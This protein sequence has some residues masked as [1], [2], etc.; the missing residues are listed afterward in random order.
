MS[1]KERTETGQAGDKADGLR[2]RPGQHTDPSKMP[3]NAEN[4]APGAKDGAPA[5]CPLCKGGPLDGH[6]AGCARLAEELQINSDD[7]PSGKDG[8][9]EV[10]AKL[11]EWLGHSRSVGSLHVMIP[12]EAAEE[13]LA[14][15]RA[16]Q[17]APFENMAPGAKEPAVSG[18]CG[19]FLGARGGCVLPDGHVGDHQPKSD[20]PWEKY[21]G[22]LVTCDKDRTPHIFLEE[23]TGI[24]HLSEPPATSL[25]DVRSLAEQGQ[26]SAILLE[27]I[28][29]ALAGRCMACGWPLDGN[30]DHG[31]DCQGNCSFRPGDR[32]QDAIS[33]H[34]AFRWRQRM[35]VLALARRPFQVSNADSGL[36]SGADLDAVV[37]EKKAAENTAAGER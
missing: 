36:P 23:C 14:I 15:L 37:A 21:H 11:R 7:L 3:G 16:W 35:E 32:H 9:S 31:C 22:K 4:V 2:H 17:E 18:L 29:L 24:I 13:I 20:D 27:M 1:E 28:R 34:E 26:P 12:C 10:I 5:I 19:V 33:E 6:V 30:P 8:G 25:P